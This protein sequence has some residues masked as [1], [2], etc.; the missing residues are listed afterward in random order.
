MGRRVELFDD[1]EWEPCDSHRDANRT[2]SRRDVE[3]PGPDQHPDLVTY[4]V[5]AAELEDCERP[6]G[7]S[8]TGA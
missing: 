2:R 1:A 5:Y 4:L 6:G 8:A 7:A 3:R